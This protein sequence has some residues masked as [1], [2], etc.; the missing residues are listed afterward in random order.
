MRLGS[1]HAAG[2]VAPLVGLRVEQWHAETL[3]HSRELREGFR[4]PG[5]ATSP[6]RM[7]LREMPKFECVSD[8]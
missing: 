2:L 4:M 6:K 7:A 5:W 3:R 1:T 8:K